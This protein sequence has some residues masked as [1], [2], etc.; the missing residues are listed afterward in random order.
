MLSKLLKRLDFSA[1]GY[2]FVDLDGTLFDD[3]KRKESFPDSLKQ[4]ESL[5]SETS[6]NVYAQVFFD[7]ACM[8]FSGYQIIILSGRTSSLKT[9]KQ[10]RQIFNFATYTYLRNSR[11]YNPTLSSRV[12]K[13]EVF[14]ELLPTLL[15][16]KKPIHFFEDREDVI[17]EII[18]IMPENCQCSFQSKQNCVQLTFST[19]SAV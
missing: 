16:L 1:T 11:L 8:F 3:T 6:D 19:K 13:R 9:H 12:L 7:L 15:N 4:Q 10:L 17:Q 5:I 2:V 14:K 18:P